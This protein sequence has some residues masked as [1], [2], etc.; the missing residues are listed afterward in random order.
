M[1]LVLNP[2]K[3]LVNFR[4]TDE[5]YR[6]LRLACLACGSRGISDF[7]RQAIVEHSHR[8]DRAAS[9]PGEPQNSQ[10]TTSSES[11]HAS[12]R[13]LIDE[14]NTLANRFPMPETAGD[15]PTNKG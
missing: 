6:E 8:L 3:R 9:L 12:L 7:A 14:L 10:T 2:R 15:L 1:D 4:V 11:F 5:E 13:R